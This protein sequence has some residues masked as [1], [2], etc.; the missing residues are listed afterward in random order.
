MAN[1]YLGTATFA[2]NRNTNDAKITYLPN[3]NTQMLGK[4]SIEPFSDP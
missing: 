2:Y 1:D 3:E 4:Y